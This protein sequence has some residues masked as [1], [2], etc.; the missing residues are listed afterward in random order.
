MARLAAVIMLLG[1]A[2]VAWVRVSDYWGRGRPV[3]QHLRAGMEYARQALGPQAEAEWKEVLRL[4]PKNTDACLLLAEYYFSA[5]QWY[6]A[7]TA[8]QRLRVLS[9]RE[10]HLN[11]KLASCYLNL[12]DEVS[13]YRFSE[14]EIKRDPDC[15]SGLA[16]SA[17]LLIR[18]G[19]KSRAAGYLRH[20]TSLEP[21]DPVLLY[22]LGEAL[23]DT[24][25]YREARPVLEQ[26]TRLDPRNADA[27][28]LL[29]SD[30]VND[31][32]APDHL[33]RA[34]RALR[35]A[36]ELN[37]LHA[38]ARLALG[39]LYLLQNQPRAAVTELEEAIRLMP[40]SSQAPF[41]LARAYEQAGQPKQATL[42]RQ[43]FLTLRQL[44]SEVSALQ[45]RSAL[46]PTVFDYPYRLGLIETRRGN[47]RRAFIWLNKA[48]SLR[49]ADPRVASALADL[50]RMTAGPSRMAAVQDRIAGGARG[51]N[52]ETRRHGEES[53]GGAGQSEMAAPSSQTS[54][55]VMPGARPAA[56][57]R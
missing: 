19:E 48:R 46:N 11:C 33:Q 43:R 10:E 36:L 52:T 18:M 8:Y 12:G 47:Y 45:K 29:G 35:Q 32:S 54:R 13:A 57:G 51:I 9:P 26:V 27:Y 34:E 28:A 15:V 31:A 50:S 42:M 30:W 41:E 22:M 14:A 39:R 7:L 40:Q 16:I 3:R 20:V 1:L 55:P 17:I 38:E 6:R 21:E 23:S 2:V 5:H 25:N 37:P 4:D 49:P 24:Y 56:A 53:E 44:S